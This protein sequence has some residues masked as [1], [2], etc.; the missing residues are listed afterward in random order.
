[1]GSGLA[2]FAAIDMN[3]KRAA[4]ASGATQKA[5]KYYEAIGLLTPIRSSNGYRTYGPHDIELVRQVRELTAAGLSVKGTKPFIEC[6]RQG[7]LHGDD[8]PES[9]AVYHDEITRLDTLVKELTSRR[10]MLRARLQAAASRGFTMGNGGDAAALPPERYGLPDNLP[11]PADDGSAAHLAGLRLPDLTLGSTD[12]RRVNLRSVSQGR[13]VL[14]VYPTTGVPGEDM[15]LGWD[16]IPGARGCTAEACGF[17]DSF[18]D[19]L[20]AGLD[21]L[22]GLSVQDSRY[23][24]ELARRLRLP[25]PLLSDPT[26]ALQR[27]LRLPVFD[28]GGRRFYRRLTM[29]VR[30]QVIE[31][32]FFPI[33]PPNEH[34]RQVLLWIRQHPAAQVAT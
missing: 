19:L 1:M 33:F 5:L 16:Q 11:V 34:A 31:H 3:I 15:P 8:C 27:T 9:L 6:L 32:V 10:E 12:G 21:Q 28:A 23:Q 22:Y 7:H 18:A 17:R 20:H 2:F 30:G 13:W 24:Q 14:F 25:Y 26:L 29:I 4:Q